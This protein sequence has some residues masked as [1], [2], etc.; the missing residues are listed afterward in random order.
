MP[1]IDTYFSKRKEP[2]CPDDF[3]VKPDSEQA[4]PSDLQVYSCVPEAS[5]TGPNPRK[6]KLGKS[7]TVEQ[8]DAIL[9]MQEPYMQQIVTG[10]K[11]YEFRKYCLRQ[12]IR[13]IWFYRTAPYSSLDY[14]CEMLPARTRNLGD[15]PLKEEGLGNKEF[16]TRHKDWEGDDF[17][18]KILSVYKLRTPI[19]L[20]ELK[21]TH[22]FKGAPRGLVYTPQSLLESVDWEQQINLR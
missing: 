15:Q 12:S 2:T 1:T 6:R 5:S 18:Y 19:P 10:E 3:L 22:G 8:T 9:P 20:S 14:V 11:T 17:A 13:R 4:N 16:N 21:S 7:P